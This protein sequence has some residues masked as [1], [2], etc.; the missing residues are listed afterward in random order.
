M[1]MQLQA[2]LLLKKTLTIKNS[3]TA[4]NNIQRQLSLTKKMSETSVLKEFKMIEQFVNSLVS[5]EMNLK[6]ID[7][8][9]IKK[10]TLLQKLQKVVQKL[11][12]KTTNGNAETNLDILSCD[13]LKK[14]HQK[15]VIKPLDLDI[16]QKFTESIQIKDSCFENKLDEEHQSFLD[17]F[18][19][20]TERIQSDH[21]LKNEINR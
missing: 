9:K 11:R 6:E 8:I 18:N 15:P 13:E 17:K 16:A 3:G 19:S 7:E 5:E 14:T 10:F 12:R 2:K 1:R 4:N 21:N 20:E